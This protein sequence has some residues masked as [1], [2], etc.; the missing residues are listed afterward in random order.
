MSTEPVQKLSKAMRREQVL[1]YLGNP[2]NPWQN[3]L[4]LA[5]NVCNYRKDRMLYV[6]FSPEERKKIEHEA[7][8][9]RR[10]FYAKYLAALDLKLLTAAISSGDTDKIRLAYQK[11]EDWAPRET[12]D[13]NFGQ[14]SS[15]VAPAKFVIDFGGGKQVELEEN[16]LRKKPE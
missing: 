5:V 4:W 9:R 1:E 16:P 14:S 8:T 2:E 10:M 7:L 13:V 6:Q 11:F 15:A 12:K 3:W